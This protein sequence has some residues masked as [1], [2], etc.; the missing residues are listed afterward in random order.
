MFSSI[1]SVAKSTQLQLVIA[2]GAGLVGTGLTAHA[3]YQMYP[4]LKKAI[5]LAY[6][7]KTIK[8][9]TKAFFK[10]LNLNPKSPKDWLIASELVVGSGLMSIAVYVD[11]YNGYKRLTK[12]KESIGE[13]LVMVEPDASSGIAAV[14]ST[15]TENITG[16]TVKE[17]KAKQ[18]QQLIL[19]I[20]LYCL[21]LMMNFPM[22]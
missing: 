10:G 3:G 14:Y 6:K 11:G 19:K 12:K 4:R 17:K 1:K 5:I 15:I 13:N 7:T 9:R 18:S 22:K 20:A 8:G 16:A 2:N 21:R